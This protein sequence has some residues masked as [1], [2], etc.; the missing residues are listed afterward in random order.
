M[1]TAEKRCQTV[2]INGLAGRDTLHNTHADDNSERKQLLCTMTPD[3]E[4]V[5]SVKAI[6]YRTKSEEVT[7]NVR[8]AT[9]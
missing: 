7:A 1:S 3:A 2:T 8:V 6:V 4:V 5:T 9:Q